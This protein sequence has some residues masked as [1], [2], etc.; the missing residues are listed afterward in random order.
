MLL[1][2]NF[3]DKKE[4]LFIIKLSKQRH[5]LSRHSESQNLT[6]DQEQHQIIIIKKVYIYLVFASA[7]L[8]LKCLWSC[9]FV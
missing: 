5:M 7:I 4:I 9:T 3:E 8:Y 6:Y 2:H 1:E